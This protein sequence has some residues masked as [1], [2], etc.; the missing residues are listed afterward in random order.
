MATV[1]ILLFRKKDCNCRSL[2]KSFNGKEQTSVIHRFSAIISDDY[3]AD[4]LAG[5]AIPRKRNERAHSM[6]EP[7]RP[8]IFVPFLVGD[9]P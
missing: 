2:I 7:V 6:N 5:N 9:F 3:F 8:L 1:L 4:I